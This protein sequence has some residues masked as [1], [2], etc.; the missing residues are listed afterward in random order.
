MTGIVLDFMT[1]PESPAALWAA[2]V[3]GV[4]V[5]VAP[6]AWNWPKV[7]KRP[8]IDAGLAI[9][10]F[11]FAFIWE[12]GVSN[13][14]GGNAQGVKD[15]QNW[16]QGAHDLALPDDAPALIT[17]DTGIAPAYFPPAVAYAQGFAAA[18]APHPCLSSYAEGALIEA[19]VAAGVH[20]MGWES[21]S[22]SFPGNMTPTA[23]TTMVQ[24]YNHPPLP[25]P[26]SW[27]YN[28]VLAHDWGQWPRP[29]DPPKKGHK[30]FQLFQ[31]SDAPDGPQKAAV[32]VTDGVTRSWASSP[33]QRDALVVLAQAQGLPTNIAKLTS[34]QA[35][36]IPVVGPHPA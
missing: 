14:Q 21:E 36:G 2:G 3:E 6:A 9:P 16:L 35:S 23:H 26:G 1:P 32:W 34:V 8:Y 12:S 28:Q 20:V 18:V 17:F 33:E 15:G 25:I 19:L 4:A 24:V 13:W 30:M 27:D 11:G 7:V 31:I 10:G 29:G 22:K 5:Y